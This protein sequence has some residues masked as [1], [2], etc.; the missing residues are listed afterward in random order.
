[1]FHEIPFSVYCSCHSTKILSPVSSYNI[2]P[3]S[4]FSPFITISKPSASQDQQKVANFTIN[5]LISLPTFLLSFPSQLPF[6]ACSCSSNPHLLKIYSRFQP[7]LLSA[8]SAT[9]SG[10]IFGQTYKLRK[11]N[12]RQHNFR[13][14]EQ[15]SRNARQQPALK[16]DSAIGQHLLDYPE[17][18]EDYKQDCFRTI[19]RA[20]SLFHTSVSEPV[21]VKTK[22]PVLYRQKEFVISLGLYIMSISASLSHWCISSRIW[23]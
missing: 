5:F 11:V 15:P 4:H 22:R 20:R 6:C 8:L 16:Y 1:M 9:N 17:C 13:Q 10:N 21:Y 12:I 7:S 3:R 14:R 2:F 19:G 23:I 18:A